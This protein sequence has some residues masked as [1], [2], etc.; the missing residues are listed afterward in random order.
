MS[1]QGDRLQGAPDFADGPSMGTSFNP[2]PH[3][4]ER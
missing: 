1:P 2:A 3:W 4:D